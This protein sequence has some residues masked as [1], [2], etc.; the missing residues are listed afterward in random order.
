MVNEIV[1]F[2]WLYCALACAFKSV[3]ESQQNDK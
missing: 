3:F 1:Y 2:T